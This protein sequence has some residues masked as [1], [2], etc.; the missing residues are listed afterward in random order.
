MDSMGTQ[1]ETFEPSF[2]WRSGMT[3]HTTGI[4]IYTGKKTKSVNVVLIH[5]N[6]QS[7][8]SEPIIVNKMAVY[9]MDTQ[10][11]TNN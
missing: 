10:V 1:S 11:I 3:R 7:I 2:P 4:Q 8:F 9:L 6:L 5:K